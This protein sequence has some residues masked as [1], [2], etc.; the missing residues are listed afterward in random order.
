MSML[1]L[2]AAEREAMYVERRMETALMSEVDLAARSVAQLML[3]VRN[4]LRRDTPGSLADN[5]LASATF[6]LASGRLGVS[7]P[8]EGARRFRENFAGFLTEGARVPTYDLVTSVY[9]AE[10]RMRPEE[11]SAGQSGG[12]GAARQQMNARMETD[13]AARDEIFEQ[14]EHEGFKTYSRNVEPQSQNAHS[15]P[16]AQ[17]EVPAAKQDVPAPPSVM[18]VTKMKKSDIEPPPLRS[19]TVSKNQSL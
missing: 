5:P 10:P 3:D 19:K 1:A 18:N 15:M 9:R 7:G 13:A 8:A 12:A 2:R 16:S 4:S 14:A 11:P 17:A 6:S